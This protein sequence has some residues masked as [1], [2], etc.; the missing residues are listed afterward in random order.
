MI[1]VDNYG[2]KILF[3]PFDAL[4]VQLKYRLF[5]FLV[6]AT[7]DAMGNPRNPYPE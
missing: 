2:N 7:R 3:F 1:N 4:T 5:E 6:Q